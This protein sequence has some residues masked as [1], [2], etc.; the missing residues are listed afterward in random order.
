MGGS[1]WDSDNYRAYSKVAQTQTREQVYK[2]SKIDEYLDPAKIQFRES[3]DSDANPLSTPIIIGLDVTGSMGFIAEAIAKKHLGCLVESI[4][5]RKP[6]TDPHLMFMGIGDAV[7]HDRAP[8][9]VTQ[10]EADTTIV[11]QLTRIWLEGNGGGNHFESYDL[12]WAFAAHKTQHDCWD[13]RNKKG[14]LFTIGD[15]L[16]PKESSESFFKANISKV[17]PQKF[18][19]VSLL[20]D[21]SERYHVFHIIINEGSYASRNKNHVLNSWREKLGW[22]ALPLDNY[23]NL[24]ETIVTAIDV[25]EG[26]DIDDAIASWGDDH[27]AKTLEKT[28]QLQTRQ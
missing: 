19:P 16:F 27:I 11:D 2:S 6:I 17:L 20:A 26:T 1:N 21:A 5:Q 25:S 23:N 8:L 24:V 9:Q 15:E 13:K 28:F 14:Y 7:A 18:T 3:R 12:P 22:R 4:L 10:F